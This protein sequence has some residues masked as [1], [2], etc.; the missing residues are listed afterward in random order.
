MKQA[1]TNTLQM[2]CKTKW[3]YFK[4]Y[5]NFKGKKNDPVR[6][7]NKIRKKN[8]DRQKD[9]K[10]FKSLLEGKSRYNGMVTEIYYSGSN[11]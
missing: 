6:T 11:Q 3:K 10:D 2:R 8:P 4:R 7:M 9:D 1:D 5:N